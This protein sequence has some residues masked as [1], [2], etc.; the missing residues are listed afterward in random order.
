LEF[1]KNVTVGECSC[2]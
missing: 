1:L 2:F